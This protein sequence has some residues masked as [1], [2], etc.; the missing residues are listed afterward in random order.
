MIHLEAERPSK[1]NIL[2]ADTILAKPG[3]RPGFKV[4]G[5]KY[6]FRDKGFCFDRMFKAQQNLDGIKKIWG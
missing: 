1:Q 5:G 3:P 4:W 2:I 6:I